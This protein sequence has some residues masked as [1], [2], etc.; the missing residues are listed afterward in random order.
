MDCGI[1]EEEGVAVLA[2]PGANGFK[3]QWGER[4]RGKTV[5]TCFDD[6]EPGRAGVSLVHQILA[7]F[8][9]SLENHSLKGGA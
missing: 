1:E 9:S 2:V 7:P 8:A 4:F 3:K 6:D 5:V